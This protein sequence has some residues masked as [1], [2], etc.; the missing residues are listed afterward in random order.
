MILRISLYHLNRI[1]VR[2]SYL[3]PV[4]INPNK[5]ISLILIIFFIIQ[6]AISVKVLLIKI[7][8]TKMTYTHAHSAG[9][10]FYHKKEHKILILIVQDEGNDKGG[11]NTYLFDYS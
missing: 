3:I 11:I 9:K 8:I 5:T 4:Q 7:C 6:K 1:N 2:K 10:L